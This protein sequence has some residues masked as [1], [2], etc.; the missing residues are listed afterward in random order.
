MLANP[1]K[2][3][4]HGYETYFSKYQ[5][6]SLSTL[7]QWWDTENVSLVHNNYVLDTFVTSNL[8]SNILKNLTSDFQKL[9]SAG[10]KSVIRFSYTLTSGNMN[11][12]T[13][14]QLLN[15]ID[16]LKPFLQVNIQYLSGYDTILFNI[17][18]LVTGK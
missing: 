18:L 13:L 9:R 17:S 10:M 3:F 14:P 6:M 5:A 15:H 11:D 12:A 4:Y 2:G 7:Q 16:Q 1:E 8:T